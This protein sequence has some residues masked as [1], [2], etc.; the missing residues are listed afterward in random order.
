L[1][2]LDLSAALW[3]TTVANCKMAITKLCK[4][5]AICRFSYYVLNLQLC[6]FGRHFQCL[7]SN[8]S[9]TYELQINIFR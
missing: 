9:L 5:G 3:Q 6:H 2:H 1:T 8:G 7:L 4:E